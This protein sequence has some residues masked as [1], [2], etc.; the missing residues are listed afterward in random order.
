MIEV[1]PS[2]IDYSLSWVSQ[3][4]NGSP[5]EITSLVGSASPLFPPFGVKVPWLGQPVLALRALEFTLLD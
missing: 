3:T 4:F 5:L 2:G 1:F